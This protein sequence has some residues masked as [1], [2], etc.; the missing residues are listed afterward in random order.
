MSDIT[1]SLPVDDL[2]DEA[3]ALEMAHD[4]VKKSNNNEV[5]Y[6]PSYAQ[7]L[8]EARSWTIERPRYPIP[9]YVPAWVRQALPATLALT[10]S[11]PIPFNPSATEPDAVRP[12]ELRQLLEATIAGEIS[13]AC[14]PPGIAETADWHVQK[15][16]A[17]RRVRREGSYEPEAAKEETD[18]P[19]FSVPGQRASREAILKLYAEELED[20]RRRAWR[21]RV[22]VAKRWDDDE[23]ESGFQVRRMPDGTLQYFKRASGTAPSEYLRGVRNYTRDNTPIPMRNGKTC[24]VERQKAAGP[25]IH[26]RPRT[27][28]QTAEEVLRTGMGVVIR[29]PTP[30]PKPIN[31]KAM[32][33]AERQA[34]R[35]AK[36]R[37]EKAKKIAAG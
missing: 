20:N 13:S 22:G 6:A 21:G 18:D 1:N 36:L 31:G 35:R 9:G 19:P 11:R 25:T 37:E 4:D 3:P 10:P 8:K 30:G 14:L 32:T 2:D 7:V 24:E 17:A 5:G 23:N 29:P 33:A 27:E 26:R 15:N 16:R 12:Y 34:R 28:G